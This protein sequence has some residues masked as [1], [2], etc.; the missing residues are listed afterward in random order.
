MHHKP[1]IIRLQLELLDF[2]ELKPLKL[3]L[4]VARELH[5]N[6]RFVIPLIHF[7]QGG[8]QTDGQRRRQT[9]GRTG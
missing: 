2:E 3:S 5:N 6:T 8:R 9:D 7:S 4:E 1:F